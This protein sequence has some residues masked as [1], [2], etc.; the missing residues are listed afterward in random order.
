MPIPRSVGVAFIALV[1]LAGCGEPA[2]RVVVY[3]V[4]GTVFVAGRPADN[5]RVMFHPL[6]AGGTPLF[7]VGV[8]RADGTFQLTTMKAGDGAPAGEYV[9][10]VLWPDPAD[11][12]DECGCPA[13]SPH[14]RLRGQY[15]DPAKT[16]LRATV[17]PGRNEVV[18]R[19]DPGARGWNLPRL[20]PAPHVRQ[21]ADR[22]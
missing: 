10:T 1:G 13:L 16:T 22:R 17:Q 12:A 14:D 7:P 20:G 11:P 9:V 4:A 19:A 6:A 5:V 3:P 15:L 8:S 18:L 2:N 21:P